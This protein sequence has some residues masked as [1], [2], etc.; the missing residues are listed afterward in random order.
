MSKTEKRS[1]RV[2]ADDVRYK[3]QPRD[4]P[5]KKAARR[6]HLTEEEFLEK[7]ANLNMRGFPYPDPTTGMYDLVV[8]DEWMDARHFPLTQSA[9]PSNAPRSRLAYGRSVRPIGTM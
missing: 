1:R 8:I 6:L 3:V 9:T 7:L 4:V 5:P 2:Y